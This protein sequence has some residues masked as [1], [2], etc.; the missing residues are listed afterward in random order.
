MRTQAEWNVITHMDRACG[1]T[2]AATRAAISPAAL[3]VNVMAR[4]SCGATSR[5]ASR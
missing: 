1:P 2:S 5:A 4:I 3:L